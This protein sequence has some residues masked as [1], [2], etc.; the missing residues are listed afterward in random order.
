MI[1]YLDLSAKQAN[2]KPREEKAIKASRKV[3][4]NND[5]FS[6]MGDKVPKGNLLMHK[7]LAAEFDMIRESLGG[8]EIEVTEVEE[9]SLASTTKDVPSNVSFEEED[10]SQWDDDVFNIGQQGEIKLPGEE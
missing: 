3:E 5:A 8:G 6:S 4:I 1:S 9:D 10:P 2:I 7:G